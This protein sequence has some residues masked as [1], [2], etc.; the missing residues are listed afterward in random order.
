MYAVLLP[1]L[2]LAWPWLPIEPDATGSSRVALALLF[3][4]IVVSFSPTVT[5]AVIADTRAR[6]PISEWC[7]RWWCWRT[8][9]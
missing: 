1:L 9:S 2:W 7:W 6:G 4:T 3:T 5:I 8:S